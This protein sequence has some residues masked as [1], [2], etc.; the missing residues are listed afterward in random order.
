MFKCICLSI[1]FPV[2]SDDPVLTDKIACKYN[3]WLTT[4]FLQF[5]NCP[6]DFVMCSCKF[7]YQ[8]FWVHYGSGKMLCMS[9]PYTLQVLFHVEGRWQY[10]SMGKIGEKIKFLLKFPPLFST[11]LNYPPYYARLEFLPQGIGS[12]KRLKNLNASHNQITGLPIDMNEMLALSV[13]DISHNQIG[14][15][16]PLVGEFQTR[17]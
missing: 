16:I 4:I 7:F 13:L 17:K 6:V 10:E 5:F 3:Q 1:R 12:L 14:S 8:I 2:H 9:I 15:L 11:P